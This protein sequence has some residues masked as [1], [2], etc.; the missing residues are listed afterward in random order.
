[1]DTGIATTYNKLRGVNAYSKVV[2]NLIRYKN[3]G[4]SRMW[5]KYVICD[6]NRTED[7]LWSFVWAMLALKPNN[8]MIC[9]DFPYGEKEI[10]DETIKF[11][12]LLW[13]VLERVTGITPIDYTNEF[14]DPQWLKYHDDLRSI[15]QE[16][17]KQKPFGDEC[18]FKKLES[19]PM[20]F[21]R[22]KEWVWGSE[23]RRSLLPNGSGLEK[24]T[25][26]AWRRT[27]GRLFSM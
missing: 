26:S 22:V 13:Y 9:P 19:T 16:L 12:A 23:L 8:I 25:V 6:I 5:L 3:S 14:G 1:M 4:T 11:A 7:D 15:I 21:V 2:A 18:A 24:F 17:I 27:F 10:P 20:S